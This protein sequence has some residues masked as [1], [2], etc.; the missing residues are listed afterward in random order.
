MLK[1][2]SRPFAV[3]LPDDQ[4]SNKTSVSM[5]DLDTRKYK[6][7]SYRLNNDNTGSSNNGDQ[8][9]R[10]N[11]EPSPPPPQ[12]RVRK[13]TVNSE[14]KERR[15]T[16]SNIVIKEIEKAK[17]TAT[18]YKKISKAVPVHELPVNASQP[19]EVP[20]QCSTCGQDFEFSEN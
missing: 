16:E 11:T 15:R 10:S 8:S 4:N 5:A 7:R 12:L 17:I 19:V 9:D 2:Y 18:K 20:S 14:S 6:E 3:L 13:K 1:I